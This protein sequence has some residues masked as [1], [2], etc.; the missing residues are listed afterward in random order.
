MPYSKP[1]IQPRKTGL[2]ALADDSGLEVDALQ[3]QPGIYSARYAGPDCSDV[4]NNQK[5]LAV[6]Q[7]KT[8]RSARYYCAMA[9]MRHAEDPTPIVCT[10]TLEGEIANEPKG[11][12]GFGYD[13]LFYIP[14]MACHAA[15]L[16]NKVK[17]TISHRAKA[18]QQLL[19]ILKT[20]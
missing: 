1:D 10:D 7:D 18:L 6:L 19:N 11:D 14:E 15:E 2:P 12:G 17:N 16:E 5:L 3:G 9:L 20:V 4:D 13:P 8:Q